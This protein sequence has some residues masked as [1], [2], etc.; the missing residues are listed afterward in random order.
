M[1]VATDGA[2]GVRLWKSVFAGGAVGS[3]TGTNGVAVGAVAASMID[4]VV[5]AGVV[6]GRTAVAVAAGGHWL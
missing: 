4:G 1:G 6:T 2:L 5:T 3:D